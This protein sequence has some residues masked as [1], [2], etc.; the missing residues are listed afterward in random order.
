MGSRGGGGCKHGGEG[1]IEFGMVAGRSW[2]KFCGFSN[3][4]NILR[5]DQGEVLLTGRSDGNL[6]DLEEPVIMFRNTPI[7]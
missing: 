3:A 4:D 2:H 7:I 6:N 1:L 5:T